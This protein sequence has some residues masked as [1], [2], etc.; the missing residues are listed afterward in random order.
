MDRHDRTLQ[1]TQK[2]HNLQQIEGET[3]KYSINYAAILGTATITASTWTGDGMEF[4][5]KANTTTS[6]AATI[7]AD[8]GRY[9]AIN[10]ITTSAGEVMEQIIN[11]H[12]TSK[13]AIP[14]QGDY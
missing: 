2:I 3:L 6:T 11:M 10:A 7:N 14:Q 13:Q 8:A 12:V 4:T 1:A 5:G 9:T